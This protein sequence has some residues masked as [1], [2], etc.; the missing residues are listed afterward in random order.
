MFKFRLAPLAAATIL[1][2][3]PAMAQ[4]GGTSAPSSADRSA[5][6][7]LSAGQT[8]AA[9]AWLAQV[10]E[11]LAVQAEGMAR[12]GQ[13]AA[14]F[15]QLKTPEQIKANG[16][17]LRAL[18]AGAAADIRRS[19]AM[20]AQVKPVV[21]ALAPELTF[22]RIRMEVLAQN[23]KAVTA[24][25]HFDTFLLA[26]EAG[27]RTKALQ[28]LPKVLESSFLLIEGQA[29]ILRNRQA[30]VP[31]T[32]S[33][34]QALGVS[35]Q[36]YRAM[37]TAGASWVRARMGGKS[38]EAAAGMRSALADVSR[39][40]RRLSAAGR[41]N[42]ARELQEID[43]LKGTGQLKPRDAAALANARAIYAEEEKV[44]ALGD[45]LA[46]LGEQHGA[47]QAA[48]LAAQEKPALLGALVGLET[49]LQAVT[50]AQMALGAKTP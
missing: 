10:G 8:E 43:A 7:Q 23:R 18:L 25:E 9:K 37:G 40:T 45:E 19:D 15:E 48:A 6:P 4:S 12:L 24:L 28:L 34:H 41:A 20:L 27:D 36:L 17:K 29:L 31:A 49:R 11:A 46:R 3:A 16:P 38:E 42:L 26:A 2:A 1:C 35:V 22:E 14:L 50:A 44:F 32:A 47:V 30:A 39:E 33:V 5:P 21:G 13:S